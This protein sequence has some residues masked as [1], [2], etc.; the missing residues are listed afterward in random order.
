MSLTFLLSAIATI[1]LFEEKI[2]LIFGFILFA[3]IKN[4]PANARIF[5]F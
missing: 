1:F 3:L 5:I 2:S 4:S